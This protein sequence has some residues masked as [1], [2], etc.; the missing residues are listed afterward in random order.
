MT[1]KTH[2]FHDANGPLPV[3]PMPHGLISLRNTSGIVGVISLALLFIFGLIGDERTR[4]FRGLLF[5]FHFWLGPTLGAMAFVMISH[6]TGGGWGVVYR[7]FGEAAFL[8]V[9]VMLIFGL[10]LAFGYNRLFPWAH[11]D[12]FRLTDPDAYGVL[13][14]RQ[15]WYTLNWFFVRQ[16]VYFAIWGWLAYMLRSGSLRLDERPDPVHRRSLRKVAAGGIVLFFFTTTS[17]AMDFIL[18]RETNWYSSIIG[19]ITA[20]EF[21]ASGMALCTL[22]LCYFAKRKPLADV[23]SPQHLNDLGNL[24]LA[25]VILW[26]YTSFAQFLIIWNG[27]TV[28]DIGYFTHRGMGKVPNPWRF[29]ALFLFLGHFLLPFFLLLMKGLKRKA[30]TLGGICVWLLIMRVVESLWV[31]APSGP[32]RPSDPSGVYLTDLFAFL[33]V[34]GIWMFN[35]LRALGEHALLPQNAT[36]QPEPI[37]HGHGQHGPTAHAI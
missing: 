23:L 37:T 35:Y 11:P 13:V 27:N 36:D 19:F 4:A 18:S 30:A 34:G 5:G 16:L 10:L 7:R 21:G 6:C 33:G 14:H 32:H 25:C 22:T 28:E 3:E 17:Y 1:D 12:Q 2:H 9:P 29:V 8:N 24:L 15:P 31:I 20:I 26:M